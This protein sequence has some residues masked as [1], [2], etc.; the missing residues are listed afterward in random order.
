MDD[1]NDEQVLASALMFM[2]AGVTGMHDVLPNDL[3]GNVVSFLRDLAETLEK[4][5][6]NEQP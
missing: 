4:K 6:R 2:G 1:L 5:S 3:K